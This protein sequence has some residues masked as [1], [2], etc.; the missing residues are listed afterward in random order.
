MD[1]GAISPFTLPGSSPT[2]SIRKSYLFVKVQ[3][4]AFVVGCYHGVLLLKP[5]SDTCDGGR[6]GQTA[7]RSEG[8]VA[9]CFVSG[10]WLRRGITLPGGRNDRKN[11][12]KRLKKCIIDGRI[13]SIGNL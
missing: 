10:T 2:A 4:Y 1:H 9:D 12:V 7:V 11:P 13:L 8:V 5:L 6:R 3:F